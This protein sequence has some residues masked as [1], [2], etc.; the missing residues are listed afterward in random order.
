MELGV[1]YTM[2]KKNYKKSFKLLFIKSQKI[3]QCQKGKGKKIRGGRQTPV[4]SL[5]RVKSSHFTQPVLAGFTKLKSHK[6]FKWFLQ[7]LWYRKSIEFLLAFFY[8]FSIYWVFSKI[9][10]DYWA[11]KCTIYFTI[12]R[13]IVEKN[14]FKRF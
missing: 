9:L 11:R 1:Y 7:V 12:N 5:C 4:P 13:A 8:S 10:I 14:M 2:H 3:S 6:H